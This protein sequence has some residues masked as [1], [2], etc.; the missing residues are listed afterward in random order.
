[1]AWGIFK[2]IKDGFKKVIGGI[3][4]GAQWIGN[5]ILKPIAKPIVNA[6]APVV[7]TIIPGVG[8]ALKTGVNAITDIT[9][10]NSRK[11]IQDL[12]NNPKI[13]LKGYR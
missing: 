5:N 6:V 11:A 13:K 10:G 9:T 1:M 8:T 4:K 3:K 12:V 7:D 2:K